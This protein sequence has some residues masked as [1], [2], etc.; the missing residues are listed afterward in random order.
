MK[1]ISPPPAG[2]A[3]QSQDE[4]PFT[5]QEL[6]ALGGFTNLALAN[7]LNVNPRTI[8]E[9]KQHPTGIGGA[10]DDPLDRMTSEVALALARRRGNGQLPYWSRLAVLDYRKRGYSRAELAAIFRCGEKTVSRI[11]NHQGWRHEWVTGKV[12]LTQ[13]QRRPPAAGYGKVE[14]SPRS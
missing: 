13:G 5:A 11:L 2:I 3:S 9:W 6:I 14:K 10:G 4:I 8:Y 7:I 12:R 1:R